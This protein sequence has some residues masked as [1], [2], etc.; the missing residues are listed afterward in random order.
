[1]RTAETKQELC[2]LLGLVVARHSGR[3]T[4]HRSGSA[5]GAAFVADKRSLVCCAHKIGCLLRVGNLPRMAGV[6]ACANAV[7][8][9]CIHF[10]FTQKIGT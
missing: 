1:M 7:L 2:F 5:I 6:D 8:L 3:A 9:E 4:H 10:I